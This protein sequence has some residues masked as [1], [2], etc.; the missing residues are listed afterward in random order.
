M[1]ILL[2]NGA[3][4][5]MLGTREPKKYG[6]T[7]LRDVKFFNATG[8]GTVSAEA[9]EIKNV[10]DVEKISFTDSL[11][12]VGSVYIEDGSLVREFK[13]S[14]GTYEMVRWT[15]DGDTYERELYFKTDENGEWVKR[16]TAKYK[17]G[18]ITQSKIINEMHIDPKTG[19]FQ[20]SVANCA[21]TVIDKGDI[22]SLDMTKFGV[23]I[24]KTGEA[25]AEMIVDGSVAAKEIKTSRI[26]T[27][28]E[29]DTEVEM[30]F[31]VDVVDE[32]GESYAMARVNKELG[33]F[34]VVYNTGDMKEVFF[35]TEDEEYY[36]Q[37]TFKKG[38]DGVWFEKRISKDEII[39]K[40]GMNPETGQVEID[41]VGE[42]VKIS[43]AAGEDAKMTVAGSVEAKEMKASTHTHTFGLAPSVSRG[44]RIREFMCHDLMWKPW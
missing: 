4:L 26:K 36:I 22:A 42:G 9:A 29:V 15:K 38:K 43:K 7:T 3:N 40:Y 18:T 19:E 1:K 14:T 6:K 23:K 5:N 30:E 2:I 20:L 32:N 39:E 25:D 37:R 34:E 16:E 28:D 44:T 33:V 41:F 8:T 10:S 13:N 35:K 21:I 17:D 27:A 24:T 31:G 11:G 12:N